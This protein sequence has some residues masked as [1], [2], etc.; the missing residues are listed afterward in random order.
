M[1]QTLRHLLS[2]IK[3]P[4]TVFALP[5]ALMGA[6][7]AERGIPA[8]R[9]IFWIIMAM[10]GARTAAMTFNRIVDKEIDSMNP[11]TAVR[12]LPSGIVTNKEAF[13]LLVFS[14]IL[15]E[16]SAYSLNQL[17][18]ILSPIALVIILGYSY[19]KRFTR[20]SHLVLGLALAIAPIGAWIAVKGTVS[21]PVL[22]LGLAVLFWVSGFDILYAI[23]DIDFDRSRGLHS[24]PRYLGVRASLLNARIFHLITFA[25]L[26]LEYFLLDLGGFYLLGLLVVGALLL[27]EHSIVSEK[28]LSRLNMAFFNMNGYIS[29]TIFAFTLLDLLL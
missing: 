1:I 2:M 12:E 18:L 5:F 29:V 6:L 16:W 19:T 9:T 25:I 27:Y 17:C 13:V 11:R 24:I 8:G 20:Y 22:L 15:F 21:L 14:I 10:I 4:H 3:F 7:L 26:F 23:Q 28:D